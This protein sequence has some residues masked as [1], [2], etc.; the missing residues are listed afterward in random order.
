MEVNERL[1]DNLNHLISICNDGKYGYETAAEDADSPELKSIFMGYSA[2]RAG[3]VTE[4]KQF[5]R[6]AGGDPD[7]GGG[8][9]GALHRAWI[10]VKSALSSKDN[11]AVL[12]ACITG[13]EAAVK[14]YDEVLNETNTPSNI[15]DILM[16]QRTGIQEALNKVQ[17][18]HNTVRT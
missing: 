4:L 8:P 16:R 11:K 9:L 18:L 1:V 5:V 14:A 6:S 10:D 2:Q 7:K 17:S 15:R 3:Y 13:E 12:G